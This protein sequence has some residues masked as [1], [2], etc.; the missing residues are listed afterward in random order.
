MNFK[1]TYLLPTSIFALGLTFIIGFDFLLRQVNGIH[2]N[3]GTPEYL[4]FFFQ[5]TVAIITGLLFWKNASGVGIRAKS[6]LFLLLLLSGLIL[7][8]LIIYGY[9]IGTGIDGF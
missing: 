8:T 3:L 5:I 4:W 2:N 7:Y 1:K 6:L 9:V